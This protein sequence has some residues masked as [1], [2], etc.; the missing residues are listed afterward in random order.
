MK[1]KSRQSGLTLMETTVVVAVVALL[2]SMGLPAI[3]TFFDSMATS[4]GT[5]AM[6]SASLASARAIAAKEQRYAGVRFQED[7]NGHQYMIF[8]VND[9][10]IRANGFRAVE[11]LQP[12]KLPETIGV[13]DLNLGSTNQVINAD[14]LINENWELT[15]TTTFS[16]IFSPSGKLVIHDVRTINKDGQTN[17]TSKDDIFNT[18]TNVV[19]EIAIFVQD[20]DK[21]PSRNRFVIYDK[22]QFD[23]INADGRWTDY[24]SALEVIYINPYTGT[25][26]NR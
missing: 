22:V 14:N 1:A 5:R 7:L 4:G 26:V 18:V 9:A 16:I 2:T 24:L 11:G 12:I 13:M 17:D 6:I 15:D 25:M 19:N 10:Q 20:A 21:E 3:R 23:K 8:I